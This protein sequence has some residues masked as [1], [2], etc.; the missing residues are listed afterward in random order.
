MYPSYQSYFVVVAV[1]LL[2]RIQLFVIPWSGI[3]GFSVLHYLPEFAQFPVRWTSD[4]NHLMLCCHLL[5]WPSVFP[6]IR[7]FSN[8][9]ALCIT[10]GNQRIGALATVLPMNIQNWFPLGLTVLIS[11]QSKGLPRV[12]FSTTFQKHQFFSAQPMVQLSHP[13]MT[14]GKPIALPRWTLVGKVMAYW[15][16]ETDTTEWLHS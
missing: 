15:K 5:L 16:A 6:S 10:S 7:V 13:Y 2:S 9:S 14:T 12:F 1:Q 3:S 4:A 11:L 8:K